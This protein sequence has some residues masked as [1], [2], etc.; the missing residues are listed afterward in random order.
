MVVQIKSGKR[1]NV[2]SFWCNLY[3]K[4]STL[5]L[6]CFLHTLDAY[7]TKLACSGRS[8]TLYTA[9]ERRGDI[10][11]LLKDFLLEAKT[12]IW[13]GLSDMMHIRSTAAGVGFVAASV[14]LADYSKVDTLVAWYKFV[15]FGAEFA[16]FARQRARGAPCPQGHLT[17]PPHLW[18]TSLSLPLSPSPS[19]S[20]PSPTNPLAPC[21]RDFARG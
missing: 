10:L 2:K 19:L 12:G 17:P 21:P 11:K 18:Q 14:D 1:E 16:N 5:P 7:W 8:R 20:H 3:R 15:N 6:P 9:S 4:R 13:P